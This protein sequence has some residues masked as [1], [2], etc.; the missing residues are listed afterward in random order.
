MVSSRHH[1]WLKE[2]VTIE[3]L[4]GI[5][6]GSDLIGVASVGQFDESD[7]FADTGG[8][9]RTVFPDMVGHINDGRFPASAMSSVCPGSYAGP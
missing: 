7:W 5:L 8:S 3:I 1:P 9:L 4:G 2:Q 6:L